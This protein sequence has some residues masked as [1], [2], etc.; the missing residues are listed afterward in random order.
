MR[1]RIRKLSACDNPQCEPVEAR[2]FIPGSSPPLNKS[3][4]VE[5]EAEGWGVLPV[6]GERFKMNRYLRN[7]VE[8]LGLL[9][10]TTV[11]EVSTTYFKTRNSIYHYEVLP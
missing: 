9:E 3:L 2:D 7:G 11:V 4:P 10:T 6:I 5:Y 1:L 8:A